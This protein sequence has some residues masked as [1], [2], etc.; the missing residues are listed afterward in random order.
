LRILGIDPGISTTGYGIIE[1]SGKNLKCLAYG[2]IHAPAKAAF[3][4]KLDSIYQKISE[5]IQQ[6]QPDF[7]AVE[8]IFYHQ[9]KK[10]A[11]V[12]G[13]ARGVV[14][15]AATR[16]NIPVFEYSPREVKMSIVGYGAASKTQVQA[17]VKNILKMEELAKPID[18][19]DALA[20]SL[21][22]YHRMKFHQLTK[23]L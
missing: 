16:K 12:M 11:I 4:Q 5:V 7:C 20:V 23:T 14:M 22:H 18:A 19:S 15:L 3:T 21:C 9:N 10:T 2:G 13:H 8:D 17:M 6:F 1:V